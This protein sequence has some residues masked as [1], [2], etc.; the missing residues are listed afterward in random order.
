MGALTSFEHPKPVN[1][2]PSISEIPPPSMEDTIIVD[3][4]SE[5]S[6]EVNAFLLYRR[7]LDV[8]T[9]YYG[10]DEIPFAQKSRM[11][12]TWWK[13][14]TKEVKQVF[15]NLYKEAKKLSARITEGVSSIAKDS[16][17]MQIKEEDEDGNRFSEYHD[18]GID[19]SPQDAFDSTEKEEKEKK[20]ECKLVLRRLNSTVGSEFDVVF[21][22]RC[23]DFHFDNSSYDILQPEI[24]YE[25][26]IPESVTQDDS[27][28]PVSN[29]DP[30]FKP[31]SNACI[32]MLH[33]EEVLP[34]TLQMELEG[35]PF[36]ISSNLIS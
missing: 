7:A 23:D 12:A 11:L 20:E 1:P 33:V 14:E 18:V 32:G 21:S 22:S 30:N 15:R 16:L 35:N 19:V 36:E 13:N 29:D 10:I 31:I 28:A 9:R 27:V 6:L 34:P 3:S 26:Y 8:D 24:K 2:F 5:I 17:E 4:D 25:D